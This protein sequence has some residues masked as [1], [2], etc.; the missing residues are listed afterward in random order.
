MMEELLREMEAYAEAYHVPIINERAREAF[1]RILRRERPHRVLELG[2]A[3]GYS[4]LL[5]AMLGADDVKVLSMERNEARAEK[6][7]EFIRRTPYGER[8]TILEGDAAELLK[9]LQGPFDFVF[10]DAAKGQYPRYFRQIQPLLAERAVVLADNVLFRGYVTGGRAPRRFRTIAKRLR[11]YVEMV[12]CEPGFTTEI[13][14]DGDGLAVSRRGRT[15][16]EA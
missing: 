16:E 3:I 1:C 11:E 7:R 13:L 2:T 6:A 12:R 9:T 10:L 5:T 8:I 4:A 15:D 14:E